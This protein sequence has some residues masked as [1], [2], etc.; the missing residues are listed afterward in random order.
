LALTIERVEDRYIASVSPPHADADWSTSRPKRRGAV[1]RAL[2]ARGAHVQ[3]V[4][5]LLDEVDAAH[6]AGEPGRA[7]SSGHGQRA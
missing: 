5:Q 7:S 6:E 3:D 2:I 1:K 4:V